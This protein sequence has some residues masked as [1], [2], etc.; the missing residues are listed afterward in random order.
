MALKL[1][2]VTPSLDGISILKSKKLQE[3]Q[4]KY[5]FMCCYFTSPAGAGVLFRCQ[6]VTVSLAETRLVT[7][8]EIKR[9]EESTGGKHSSPVWCTPRHKKHDKITWTVWDLMVLCSVCVFVGECPSG[10]V[11]YR[12]NS[13]SNRDPNQQN[14]TKS[15][16]CGGFL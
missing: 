4:M 12:D 10:S 1:P 2:Y 15:R 6:K 7:T 9:H 16:L 14:I 5:F 11:L 3:N 13:S 8:C